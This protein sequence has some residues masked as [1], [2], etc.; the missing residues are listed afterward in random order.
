MFICNKDSKCGSGV[1][2][3]VQNDLYEMQFVGDRL[4][5]TGI[6]K[7]FKYVSAQTNVTHSTKWQV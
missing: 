4:T 3:A 2:T 5:L 7:L 1:R 6:Y